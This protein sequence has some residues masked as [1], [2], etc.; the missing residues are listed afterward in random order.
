M[1]RRSSGSSEDSDPARVETIRSR[2]PANVNVNDHHSTGR[3]SLSNHREQQNLSATPSSARNRIS[4]VNNV[5]WKV[6][7]DENGSLGKASSAAHSLSVMTTS[8]NGVIKGGKGVDRRLNRGRHSW[9]HNQWAP[10]ILTLFTTIVGIVL[11]YAVL[12]SSTKLHCDVKGCRMSYMRPSYI[13]FDDFDTEHTRFASKYSLYLYRE[14][15]ANSGAKVRKDEEV[16][17][18]DS[19]LTY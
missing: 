8:N 14:Q 9:S 7:Q 15:G 13:K 12:G 5:D 4:N 19:L 1:K 3:R 18:R 6:G 2:E 10:S 17:K 11:L 16:A